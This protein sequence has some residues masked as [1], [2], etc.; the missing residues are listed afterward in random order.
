MGKRER[1][2]ISEANNEYGKSQL[3]LFYLSIS[4]F[5]Q[6]LAKREK[7]EKKL[8]VVIFSIIRFAHHFLLAYLSL[9]FFPS[10]L[11]SLP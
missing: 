11:L 4:L 3:S 9:V 2:R 8:K 7:E 10:S 5:Y 6:P 1:N